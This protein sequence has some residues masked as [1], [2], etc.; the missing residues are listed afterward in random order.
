[1]GVPWEY[2]P[3]EAVDVT[4]VLER[5][6]AHMRKTRLPYALIMRKGTVA[7]HELGRASLDIDRYSP[8]QVS[9]ELT[10]AELPAPVS[11]SDALQH[12]I[13]HTSTADS[14]L[15]ATTGFT[16]R[17]LCA[18]DDRPN[19]LYM[20][21]SMGC[22]SSLGLGLALTRADRQVVVIDGDGAALMRMGNFATAGTCGGP[23]FTHIVLDNQ[24]HDS[25][26][27]QATVSGGMSFAGVA[28]ACGYRTV[29]QGND[30]AL[31]DEMLGGTD[32]P[33]PAF[34]HLHTRPGTREG[35]PRPEV[36]PVQV[37]DRLMQHLGTTP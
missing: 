9:R 2:F 33:R 29:M 4:P 22:A 32:L 11:R 34:G 8:P 16:G 35:L 18:L 28:A 20:V 25:T 17:E 36:S 19:Q 3:A 1:M 26:G 14:V 7:P 31:L 13:D 23:N 24:V 27:A 37:C 10:D 6:D 15:I 5:I 21:G 30:L 12:I